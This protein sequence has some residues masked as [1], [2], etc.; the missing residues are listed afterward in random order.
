MKVPVVHYWPGS[1]EEG[2]LISFQVDVDDNF[3]R[4]AFYV[5]KILKGA[6]PGELPI[7][8][9]TRYEFVLNVR[10]ANALNLAIPQELLLRAD[11]VIR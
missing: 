5:D 9:P 2:A 1:A 11:K 4:A 7:D 8:R 10:V 3:R 6:T